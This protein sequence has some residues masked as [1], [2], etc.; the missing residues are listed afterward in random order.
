[1]S[2]WGDPANEGGWRVYDNARPREGYTGAWVQLCI[3]E[4]EHGGTFSETLQVWIT[5]IV[6]EIHRR[7]PGIP[8]WLSPL[9][10]YDGIVCGRVGPDGPAIAAETADWAAANIP[11]VERG[12]DLGPLTEEHINPPD[13][14]HANGAGELLLGEQLAAFFD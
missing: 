6:E 7:D 12:P 4:D 14:C 9:N 13:N 3:E 5:N 2:Q 10:S 11:G 1:M 8:V